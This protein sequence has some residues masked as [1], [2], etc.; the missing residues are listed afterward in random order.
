M[1]RHRLVIAIT[2][3]FASALTV[4]AALGAVGSGRG[5]VTGGFTLA[6]HVS[7]LYPGARR[8]LLIVVRNRERRPL[9]VGSV[10]TRVRDASAACSGRNLHVSR[11]RGRLRLAGRGSRRIAVRVWMRPE[12]PAAWQGAV[13]PLVFRGWATRG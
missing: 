12:S 9:R 3:A 1:S 6:G 8:R 5:R 13:F 11:F 2:L 7:G 4:A 10:T